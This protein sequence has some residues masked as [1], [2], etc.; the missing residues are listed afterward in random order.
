[1]LYTRDQLVS[2][3]NLA[4]VSNAMGRYLHKFLFDMK[5]FKRLKWHE[6]DFFFENLQI[7]VTVNNKKAF[8]LLNE[9]QASDYLFYKIILMFSKEGT[10]DFSGQVRDFDGVISKKEKGKYQSLFWKSL[11]NW[12]VLLEEPTGQYLS[13]LLPMRNRKMKEIDL[14]YADRIIS[15]ATLIKRKNY[16]DAIFYYI[17]YKTRCHFDGI[18]S[19]CEYRKIDNID[20]YVDIYTYSHVLS[21][22]YMPQMNKDIGVSLNN[23]IKYVDIRNLPNSLLQLVEDYSSKKSISSDTEYLLFVFNDENYILWLKYG[24]IHIL[25]DKVGMEIRSFYKC[26]S[27]GDL[28]K[29]NGLKKVKIKEDF[30]VF[31]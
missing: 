30:Y 1:M 17:Y 29:F 31:I 13:I 14:L 11:S 26:E 15:H 20:V 21:R 8:D 19:K 27:Q 2:M 28:D 22:H 12:R 4:E 23:D 7:L 10:F 9:P 18:P 24:E 16:T 3:N 5:K 25:K 6:K